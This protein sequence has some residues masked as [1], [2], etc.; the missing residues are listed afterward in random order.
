MA[1]V[2]WTPWVAAVLFATAGFTTALSQDRPT[3]KPREQPPVAISG[4]KYTYVEPGMHVFDCEQTD[5]L[6]GAKVSYILLR[7]AG[8]PSFEQY[9]AERRLLEAELKKRVPDGQIRMYEIVDKSDEMFTIFE[10]RREEK[11]TAG[12][13]N[14]VTSIRVFGKSTGFD[15]ISS[16]AAANVS[17]KNIQPF[18]LGL[19]MTLGMPQSEVPR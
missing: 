11:P 9:K 5:C 15:L 17:D 14:F 7:T 19:M 4:Y 3:D 12:P 2:R 8:K 1:N 13:S 18:L 10:S 6:P 16:S